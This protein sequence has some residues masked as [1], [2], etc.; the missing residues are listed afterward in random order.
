[1]K[2][3]TRGTRTAILG[4]DLG[5]RYSYYVLLDA[6]GLVTERGR[7]MTKRAQFEAFA[8]ARQ[9]SL[10]VLEAGTHS[11]WV[12]RLFE[13]RGHS[14]VVAN[15]RRVRLIS[16]SSSK[17]D[18]VDAELLARLGRAD[19]GL[20]APVRH[21]GPEAQAA[22]SVLRS[23]DCLV[24]VRTA[25]VNHVRGTVKAVGGWLP[26]CSVESFPRRVAGH[27]P[28]EIVP[29][30]ESLL[31]EIAEMTTRIRSYDH[32][33]EVLVRERFPEAAAL[34]QVSGVGSLTALAYVLTLEDPARF[35]HSR[36]VGSYLGLRPR[37]HDSGTRRPE[38]R[39][40]KE[41]DEF[42]RRL[43]VQAAHYILGPF[44]PDTDLRRWGMRLVARGGKHAKQRAAVA[45]ARKL[46]VLLHR[47]WATQATYEP[48]RQA[49]RKAA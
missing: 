15:P 22:L 31:E 24:R 38:L 6:D 4:L 45:V 43:L 33:I 48:L 26:K 10:V 37:Q 14:V 28:T 34:Q 7:L 21:R 42:L 1:M 9:S 40:T 41:G 19:R 27:V 49:R 36:T 35:P 47:L 3:K 32:E 13:G 18:R 16:H 23:R 30:V 2:A 5:D 46:A 8:A 39:I 12:S 25:L 29:A 44:G 20:L 17:R 11:P